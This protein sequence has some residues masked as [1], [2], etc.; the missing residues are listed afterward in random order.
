[1]TCAHWLGM[2]SGFTTSFLLVSFAEMKLSHSPHLTSICVLACLQASGCGLRPLRCLWAPESSANHK[3]SFF[4]FVA[5]QQL[6]PSIPPL[7]SPLSFLPLVES[8]ERQATRRETEVWSSFIQN[9]Q[10]ARRRRR[11][12]SR[13]GLVTCMHRVC[14]TTDLKAAWLKES[15]CLL[16]RSRFRHNQL[17]GICMCASE[18]VCEGKAL[19][20]QYT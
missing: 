7:N 16:L 6:S 5:T 20:Q 15:R 13:L 18:C 2:P 14:N 11:T 9:G 19:W 1:M 17:R 3:G 12:G 8:A 4:L 10:E